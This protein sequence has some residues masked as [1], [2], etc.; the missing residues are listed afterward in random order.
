MPF[1][2]P[3]LQRHCLLRVI[4]EHL[5]SPVILKSRHLILKPFAI[6]HDVQAEGEQSI[7]R[8]TSGQWHCQLQGTCSGQL[9]HLHHPFSQSWGVA[10][11]ESMRVRAPRGASRAPELLPLAGGGPVPTRAK[12]QCLCCIPP[13][14]SRIC[15]CSSVFCTD[16]QPLQIK[17]F[18][19]C[20]SNQL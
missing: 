2:F 20:P 8:V 19:S 11:R 7:F 13:C 16:P 1:V 14:A 12:A 6:S 9:P 17:E 4:R 18:K 10:L 15:P 5:D 3:L